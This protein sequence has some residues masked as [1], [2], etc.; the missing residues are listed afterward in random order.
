MLPSVEAPM[1]TSRPT[2]ILVLDDNPRM[3]P[4][5]RMEC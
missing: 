5:G 2:T 3:Q 4:T 1:P